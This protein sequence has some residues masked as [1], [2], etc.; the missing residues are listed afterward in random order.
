MGDYIGMEYNSMVLEDYTWFNDVGIVI[1][2]DRITNEEKAYIKPVV[3]GNTEKADLLN[4]MKWGT[5]FPL[6]AAQEA[7]GGF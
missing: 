7:I 5:Q 4:I 6:K 2:R 3:E 1:V